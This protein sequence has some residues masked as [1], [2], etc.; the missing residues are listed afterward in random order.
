MSKDF[1]TRWLPLIIVAVLGA[2]FGTAAV[3]LWR[4]RNDP[5]P[6]CAFYADRTRD[7]APARCFGDFHP[8]RP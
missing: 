4:H 5:E 7:L 3:H 2:Y 6:P 1:V 8:E